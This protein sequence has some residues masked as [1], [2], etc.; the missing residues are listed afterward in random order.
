VFLTKLGS[1]N[2]F[3]SDCNELIRDLT[4]SVLCSK[5]KT[6][7]FNFSMSSEQET[8]G[9]VSSICL[10]LYSESNSFFLICTLRRSNFFLWLKYSPVLVSRDSTRLLSCCHLLLKLDRLAFKVEG[11]SIS[12]ISSHICSTSL[13]STSLV[14][15]VSINFCSMTNTSS[16]SLFSCSTEGISEYFTCIHSSKDLINSFIRK[17]FPF[18]FCNFSMVW[19]VS[20]CSTIKLEFFSSLDVFIFFAFSTEQYLQI[21]SSNKTFISWILFKQHKILFFRLFNWSSSL[22]IWATLATR[23][24]SELEV[25]IHSTSEVTYLF[26]SSRFFQLFSK[27]VN[28]S[29]LFFPTSVAS[30]YLS[31][32]LCITSFKKFGGLNRLSSLS[33]MQS[34]MSSSIRCLNA[35]IRDSICIV[36]FLAAVASS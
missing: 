8:I 12:W 35:D 24:L 16:D 14:D 7:F 1:F 36:F 18:K 28:R 26:I 22:S 4:N 5:L 15:I 32:K 17:H 21:C 33:F 10:K 23:I 6:V 20:L 19:S 2:I 30:S 34:V 29:F 3:A 11:F 31:F 9:L 13:I 27:L 25:L